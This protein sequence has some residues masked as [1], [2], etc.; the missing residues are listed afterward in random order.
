MQKTYY[1]RRLTELRKVFVPLLPHAKAEVHIRGRF[2]TDDEELQKAL[3]SCYEFKSGD[4]VLEHNQTPQE[5]KRIAEEIKST[6]GKIAEDADREIAEI[7]KAE[8]KPRGR[9]KRKGIR[10]AT[11]AIT[12]QNVRTTDDEEGEA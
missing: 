12:S 1:L 6:A 3:E 7:A 5:T 4:L 8:S 2:S 11:G 9:P 10:M